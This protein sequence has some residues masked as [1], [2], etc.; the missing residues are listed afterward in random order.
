MILDLTPR[1]LDIIYVLVRHESIAL[2]TD[3]N[4]WPAEPGSYA[5]GIY[6]LDKKVTANFH[7]RKQTV[8]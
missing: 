8:P 2:Q 6:E 4:K 1:D 3:T 5:N 7:K